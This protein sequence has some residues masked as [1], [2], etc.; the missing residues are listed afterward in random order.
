MQRRLSVVE[1]RPWYEGPVQAVTQQG[2]CHWH[3][4]KGVHDG[5]MCWRGRPF[6]C[7]SPGW[8]RF[9]GADAGECSCVFQAR[10]LIN[11]QAASK[12]TAK[13]GSGVSSSVRADVTEQQC[14]LVLQ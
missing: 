5:M 7:V 8:G 14:T 10:V 12:A 11:V 6:R 3:P 4:V 9:D 2:R 1:C 13:A